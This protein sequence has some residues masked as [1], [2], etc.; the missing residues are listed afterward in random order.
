[1]CAGPVHVSTFCVIWASILLCV[2]GFIALE[3]FR[4]NVFLKLSTSSF[5]KVPEPRGERLESAHE[6]HVKR[7]FICRY[8]DSPRLF[9]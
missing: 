5:G 2:E 8:S 6:A 3:S 1:M 9:V 7:S 4:P